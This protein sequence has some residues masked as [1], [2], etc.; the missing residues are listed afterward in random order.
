MHK[1]QKL[2][3]CFFLIFLRLNSF[4]R[5]F[6]CS[7]WTYRLSLSDFYTVFYLTLHSNFY[8]AT[9]VARPCTV[10]CRWANRTRCDAMRKRGLCC[11]P[12]VD[13]RPSVT[14]VDCI[15]TAEDNTM[16]SSLRPGLYG[17]DPVATV[18]LPQ[19]GLSSQ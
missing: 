8:G 16:I 4:V 2:T 9:S 12:V 17:D 14:S 5:S 11:R 15:Q 1:S 6:P 3:L 18:R 13:R 19:R 7:C 10:I